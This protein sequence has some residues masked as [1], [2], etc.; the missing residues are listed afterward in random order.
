MLSSWTR[1]P[2]R[3]SAEASVERRNTKTAVVNGRSF[4][5]LI[6][7]TR[8]RHRGVNKSPTPEFFQH[9]WLDVAAADDGDVQFG[10]RE[11]IG[12]KEESRGGNCAAG[13]GDG[14]GI[15]G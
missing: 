13:F 14:F 15:R 3:A 7:L 4:I 1:V 12:A 6:M 5:R 2:R 10:F 11:L 9:S 8:A